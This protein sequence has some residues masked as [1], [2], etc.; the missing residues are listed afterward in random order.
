MTN[1]SHTSTSTSTTNHD[2]SFHQWRT[3]VIDHELLT[4]ERHATIGREA[5]RRARRAEHLRD[6]ASAKPSLVSPRAAA[7]L[8]RHRVGAGIIAAGSIIAGADDGPATS[9]TVS[10]PA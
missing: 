1:T 8:L 7:R 2:T 9:G 6:H 5:A 10:R 3:P 4:A